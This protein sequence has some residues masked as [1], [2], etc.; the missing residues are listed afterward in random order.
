M[1]QASKS[2]TEDALGGHSK[3]S[4][5]PAPAN[6]QPGATSNTE[7]ALGGAKKVKSA[8]AHVGHANPH[9][10]QEADGIHNGIPAAK[11]RAP[12]TAKPSSAGRT[13]RA[14]AAG[15]HGKQTDAEGN[16]NGVA[17]KHPLTK[18]Y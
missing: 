2:H 1:S 3:A 10:E 7:E 5:K 15:H 16:N 17:K 8:P 14:L 13:Q 4:Q 6:S 18:G 11:N 9:P 12:E